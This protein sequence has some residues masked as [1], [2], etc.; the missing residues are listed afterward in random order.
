MEDIEQDQ[1]GNCAVAERKLVTI[2][3]EIQPRIREEVGRNG[4]RKHGF[5]IADARTNLH[6]RSWKRRINQLQNACVKS[7]ID[8]LQQRL[9][10][11]GR[12]VCLDLDAVLF[13][14]V[15]AKNLR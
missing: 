14:G 2:A 4:S 6:D 5:Q 11:P 12:E 8:L 7:A 13:A 15:H 1:M 9:A 3:N 10:L